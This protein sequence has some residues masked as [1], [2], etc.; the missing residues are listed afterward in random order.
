M[1]TLIIWFTFSNK[2]RD[3]YL[4]FKCHHMLKIIQYDIIIM[5]QILFLN[6][7]LAI[8]IPSRKVQFWSLCCISPN[9]TQTSKLDLSKL[10]SDIWGD[11]TPFIFEDNIIITQWK[12]HDVIKLGII[13]VLLNIIASFCENGPNL[14]FVSLKLHFERINQVQ[15]L[16]V[17]KYHHHEDV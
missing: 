6:F 10:E 1:Q 15:L 5:W 8:L 11:L 14:N 16:T 3:L 12:L 4:T 2:L 17:D 13:S 7:L 9:T